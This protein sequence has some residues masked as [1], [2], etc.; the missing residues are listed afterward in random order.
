MT[1]QQPRRGMATV[2]GLVL[3]ALIAVIGTS[4]ISQWTLTR[5][6]VDQREAR[7]QAVW[8]ARSGQTMALVQLQADPNYRGGARATIPQ[9]DVPITVTKVGTERWQITVR[10]DYHPAGV[11]PQKAIL[12]RTVRNDAGRWTVEEVLP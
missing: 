10:V 12:T 4:A 6:A 8:L 11:A 9:A 3:L 5:R 1:P 7:L 2:L